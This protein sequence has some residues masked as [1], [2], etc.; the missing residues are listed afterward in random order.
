MKKTALLAGATAFT[1]L[2]GTAA[3][4]Q[5]EYATGASAT[6]VGAIEDRITDV[7]DAVRDDFARSQD[8]SRFGPADRRQ[9]TSGSVALT[10][11]GS[12]GNSDAQDLSIAGRVSHNQGVF[13]QSI[14]LLIE[15]SE[16]DDGVKDKQD[17]YAI[18]D[19]Q[20]YFND[21]FYAFGL[22][23][24]KVDGLAE[25]TDLERDGLLAFGPGYRI[26]NTPTTAWRVQAGVGVRYTKAA[27]ESS[28]TELGY[29]ASSRFYHSFNDQ[30]FLTNDTDYVTS[31]DA[32]DVI[33]NELGL[34]FRMTDAFSTRVSYR[35][36]YEEDR[37][38]RT[39]NRLGVSLV[40]GF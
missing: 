4:A 10:Y 3:F 35:T 34:N 12:T 16:N 29:I 37:D 18:Y 19:A 36:E 1:A 28:D 32:P 39:D 2:F 22:G 23:R 40:Y 8:A 14:G 9:G 30:F 21:A 26:I 7:E 33:S 27:G 15:F 11:T 38:I 5:Q 31:S 24:I 13:A 6:G 17:T 25:G 20:Y